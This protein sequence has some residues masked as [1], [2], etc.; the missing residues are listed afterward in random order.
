M[1]FDRTLRPAALNA[2]NW[3][4]K[5]AA[6]E[7]VGAAPV[8]SSGAIVN[9]ATAPGAPIPGGPAISYRPPPFDVLSSFGIPAPAFEDFPLAILP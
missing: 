7:R 6:F 4:L 3:L 5:L 1:T 8:T 2:G 9:G